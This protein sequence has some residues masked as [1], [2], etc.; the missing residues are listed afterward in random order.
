MFIAALFLSLFHIPETKNQ[1]LIND[2][3]I[4]VVSAMVFCVDMNRFLI[5]G[6]SMDESHRYERKKTDQTVCLTCDLI[7]VK[8]WNRAWNLWDW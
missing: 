1:S 8:F 5:D 6:K 2:K 7:W 3:Q 4:C